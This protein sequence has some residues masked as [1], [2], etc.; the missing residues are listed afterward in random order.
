MI[1]H[2]ARQLREAAHRSPSPQRTGRK[3]RLQPHHPHP[4]RP[5]GRSSQHVTPTACQS[6]RPPLNGVFWG[7]RLPSRRVACPYVLSSGDT[8][9]GGGGCWGLYTLEFSTR[10]ACSWGGEAEMFGWGKP[11]YLDIPSY[12]N[13]FL[14]W[15]LTSTDR[16]GTRLNPTPP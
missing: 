10:A 2:R 1:H 14:L 9:G 5:Q 8:V 3:C 4:R 16:K 12:K 6:I 11:L 7:K 15:F 13:P